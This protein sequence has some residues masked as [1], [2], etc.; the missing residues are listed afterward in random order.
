MLK[1]ILVV[2]DD[3]DILEIVSFILEEEYEV[4][5][6][7]DGEACEHLAGILPD[8]ILMDIRLNGA[9]SNGDVIC[10]WLKAGFES[11]VSGDPVICGT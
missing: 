2:E 9:E 1:K 11:V 4:V 8:L 3:V 5:R 6:S 7:E 10:L